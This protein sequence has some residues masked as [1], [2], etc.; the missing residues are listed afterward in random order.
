MEKKLGKMEMKTEKIL[1]LLITVSYL[2]FSPLLFSQ[3][4][5][6][7]DTIENYFYRNIKTYLASDECFEI[8]YFS[9]SDSYSVEFND[10]V[11]INELHQ[12]TIDSACWISNIPKK[13]PTSNDNDSIPASITRF[14]N[15]ILIEMSNAGSR[16]QVTDKIHCL[17]NLEELRL[18]ADFKQGDLPNEI[19]K[20]SNLKLIYLGSNELWLTDEMFSELNKIEFIEFDAQKIPYLPKSLLELPN[21]RKVKIT[22]SKDIEDKAI[23]EKLENKVPCFI[24]K[25]RK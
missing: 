24:Y 15:I 25:I 11:S 6:H 19:G 22:V 5:K 16:L 21:L 14:Q 4:I 18:E 9:D 12:R 20:L 17:S 13:G 8:I 10:T 2:S 3:S 23:L 7:C 1:K